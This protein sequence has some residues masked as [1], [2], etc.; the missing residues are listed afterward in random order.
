M[1][2][3]T[4]IT[5]ID[6]FPILPERESLSSFLLS[7][8]NRRIFLEVICQ[9][10]RLEQIQHLALLIDTLLSKGI[11]KNIIIVQTKLVPHISSC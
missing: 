9:L 10:L 3:Y 2:M 6:S 1:K 8:N 11:N 5:L 4:H 7:P